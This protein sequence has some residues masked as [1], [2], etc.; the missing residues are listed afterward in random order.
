M[1]DISTIVSS[2]QQ[3]IESRR[4][5]DAGLKN[6]TGGSIEAL[7]TYYQEQ[8]ENDIN[9]MKETYQIY[10]D[11]LSTEQLVNERL[12]QKALDAGGSYAGKSVEYYQSEI[13]R[14]KKHISKKFN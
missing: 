10:L 7:L 9:A 3:E 14:I 12:M 2:S 1:L 8:K 13:E 6:V 11:Q 5:F 4:K